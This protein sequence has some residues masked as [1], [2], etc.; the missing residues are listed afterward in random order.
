MEIL[1]AV[2][3]SLAFCSCIVVT[4]VFAVRRVV[5]EVRRRAVAVVD[6]ASLLT[7]AHGVGP[8]AEAARLRRT[9]ARSL[10]GARR[11]LA[12]SHAVGGPVGDV[13]S[14][15]ARLEL[16]AQSVDGE[17][18]LIAAQPD[19]ARAAAALPGPRSRVDVI[20][21][22][23]AQLVDG[24]VQAAGHDAEQLG[25]LQAACAIEADALRATTS[26]YDQKFH[27]RLAPTPATPTIG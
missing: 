22:S 10:A 20:T 7:R 26:S 12:A 25:L 27:H 4:G 21:S 9:L 14:L 15:L 18:R 1:L 17:L 19:R 6:R 5:R 2:L 24:L 23:A 13:R 11:A 16:A 8:A 3:V